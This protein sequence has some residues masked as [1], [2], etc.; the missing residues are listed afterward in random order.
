MP[1]AE[2]R[3]A[4]GI[5]KSDLDKIA[6]SPA[7]YKHAV[8][9]ETDAMRIGTLV[10]QAV[11]QQESLN[12]VMKPKGMTFTTKEGKAWR[13]AQKGTTIITQAESDMIGGIMNSV[14]KHP[15]AQKLLAAGRA[16]QSI[17]A[18]DKQGT[19]R[20]GRTDWL[21]DKTPVIVDLKT[22]ED[23]RPEKFT[24]S[25]LDYRYHV[26]AAYYID[27]CKLAGEDR[28]HFILIAVEKT[29]P[30]AVMVYQIMDEDIEIGRSLYRRDL[31]VYRNCLASGQWPAYPEDIELIGI[32]EY[33]K[34][35]M[36]NEQ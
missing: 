25:I 7:H 16:E 3:K 13:D 26:Q 24:R 29:P 15:V 30:Y 33:A 22:C 31:Q 28:R 21:P 14:T 17:F 11:F 18:V 34:Q 8:R 19:L 2:Y 20:K 1:E 36:E 6:R 5:S 12:Y 9:E 35:Q 23:A 32:P 27:L 10:H 4:D